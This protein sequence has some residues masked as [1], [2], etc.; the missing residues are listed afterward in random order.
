MK[1]RYYRI[2]KNGMETE[3]IFDVY[4]DAVCCAIEHQLNS[5]ME[6]VWEIK[7]EMK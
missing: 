4:S 7:E 3:F 5:E 6:I 2:Y 1:T